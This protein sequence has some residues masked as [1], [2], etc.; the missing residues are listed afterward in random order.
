VDALGS[1]SITHADVRGTLESAVADPAVRASILAGLRLG[2][3]REAAETRLRA[4]SAEP[5]GGRGGG[6]AETRIGEGAQTTSEWVDPEP[7]A[8]RGAE[9][10]AEATVGT[11]LSGRYLLERR[12]GEGGMGVVYL[13]S[14]QEVK[15]ETFA[16]KVL[17]AEIREHP[18]SL[19]LLREE[20][21]RTRALPHPN[22]VGV[23]SLNSDR[24]NVYMLMEFLEGKSLD[25]L[26]DEDFGRGMPF[27]RAWPLI[28]DIGGALA[29]AHDHSVIHSDL[30]PS[31]IFITT[32]GRAKLVDFG[33][34]RVARGRYR[35]VDPAALG[36]LTPQYASCEMLEGHAPDM[37]DDIYALAC[38]IY[39]MLSGKHPFGG[40]TAVEA[41]DEKRTLPPLPSL[42]RAQNAALAS[43]LA[44]DREQRVASVEALIAGLSPAARSSSAR[45][46]LIVSAVVVVI[47]LAIGGWLWWTR[48]SQVTTEVT[49][50][51]TNRSNAIPASAGPA[52]TK[53]RELAD[54]AR[55]LEVD[56]ADPTLVQGMQQLRAAEQQLAAGQAGAGA[57]SLEQAQTALLTALA[58]GGR[59]AHVGS[60]AD[61]VQL[62]IGLCNRGGARCTAADFA[63]EAPRTVVLRP[64]ALDTA[65]VTNAQ[66][67]QFAQEKGFTTTAER[68]QGLFSVSG[69]KLM[70]HPGES[71]KTLWHQGGSETQGTQLPVRGIDFES[72]RAFCAWAGKRLPTEEEWE[73]V[74]RPDHRI[75]PWG[76]DPA[77]APA[78]ASP[79]LLPI[80]EQKA[81]GRFG[82]R[83]QGGTLWEWVDGGT[84]MD[85]VFRGASWLDTDIVHRR[86]AQRGLEGPT[87]A[88]VD[89]GF[90][91]AQSVDRWPAEP[92]AAAAG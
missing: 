19:A 47:V 6:G 48:S 46:P 33:I 22:I 36:A 23:Y 24:S 3:A 76:N 60:E 91:C 14:D 89:T 88:H 70:N 49:T 67:T 66:F 77:G 25:A 50:T 28:Q 85:R 40:R 51:S 34:A 69:S 53:A 44:F 55:R 45:V 64:F 58:S 21:R 61:E 27:D 65:E 84:A 13:A 11:L 26:I 29:F 35:G 9:P 1:Q 92:G 71:W 54:E 42:S 63:D 8:V 72:A 12:L 16:V 7:A 59:V 38:V 56:P 57:A 2:P 52:L 87:R 79:R 4:A 31:N 41:R 73:Y 20:V 10:S 80:S 32:G 86:L 75:F 68:G 18:E 90:R 82:V 81:T 62:A 74:A 83:G 37:R 30:K 39:E 78:A 43:G 15:G 5:A 17:K